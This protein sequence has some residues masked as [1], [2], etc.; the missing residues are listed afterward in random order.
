AAI[1][2]IRTEAISCELGIPP[3]PMGGTFDADKVDVSY[4]LDGD[5]TRFDYEPDCEVS[6]A[7][8]YDD[9]DD[10]TLIVLCPETCTF[11]QSTP[12]AELNVDF[13]CEDRPVVVR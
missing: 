10:P 8:H 2:Q 4:T 3:H 9:E 6:G 11:V 12:G 1:D 7:W 5:S 13:L